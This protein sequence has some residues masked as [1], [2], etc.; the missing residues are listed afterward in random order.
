MAPMQGNS[1]E[2]ERETAH[3]L[4]QL[5]KGTSKDAATSRPREDLHITSARK[6]RRK[7]NTKKEHKRKQAQDDLGYR[8]YESPN[9]T[10]QAPSPFSLN[11]AEAEI[12]PTKPGV[13]ITESQMTLDDIPSD[14]EGIAALYREFEEEKPQES[15]DSQIQGADT[16][17][18]SPFESPLHRGD[19]K[20][21]QDLMHGRKEECLSRTSFK[22]SE[23]QKRL[24]EKKKKKKQRRSSAEAVTHE[25]DSDEEV[26]SRGYT[27]VVGFEAFD[28]AFGGLDFDA[29]DPFGD[30]LGEQKSKKRKRRS[31]ADADTVDEGVQEPDAG[32][33]I[34]EE[35]PELD[36]QAFDDF[37][38]DQNKEADIF[39]EHL[40]PFRFT[41]QSTH[42]EVPASFT[43]RG[44]LGAA[45]GGTLPQVNYMAM[46]QSLLDFTSPQADCLTFVP[47]NDELIDPALRTNSRTSVEQD[48]LM[49]DQVPDTQLEEAEVLRQNE[50]GSPDPG[51]AAPSSSSRKKHKKSV[52][53]RFWVDVPAYVSPYQSIEVSPD[54]GAQSLPH[55]QQSTQGADGLFSSRAPSTPQASSSHQNAFSAMRNSAETTPPESKRSERHR[56]TSNDTSLKSHMPIQSGTYTEREIMKLE[57]FRDEYLVANDMDGYAFNEL[58]HA[59]FM[60][61]PQVRELWQEIRSILP[62][63]DVKQ[64]TKFCRR[65]FHNFQARGVWTPEEDEMLNAAVE[66]H[67]RAWKAV[68]ASIDRHPED[69]R[70][71]WRNYLVN[72][73]NRNHEK[74]TDAEV[75][76][77]AMAID[78]CVYL[79]KRDR[80]MKKALKYEGREMPVSEDESDHERAAQRLVNWQ[81][82]SD[83]MGHHGGGRSRLQCSMKWAQ[84][85]RKVRKAYLKEAELARIDPSTQ[86]LDTTPKKSN[87]GW[88]LRKG[89]K[90]ANNMKAGDKQDLLL[91]LTTCPAIDEDN[92]PWRNLGPDGF[93]EKW[94]SHDKRAAWMKLRGEVPSPEHEDYHEVANRLY[95][96]ICMTEGDHLD[97]RGEPESVDENSKFQSSVVNNKKK[98]KAKAL[99]EDEKKD[100]RK[101]KERQKY[102]R[103]KERKKAE[104]KPKEKRRSTGLPH[105]NLSKEYVESSD[106]ES[107]QEVAPNGQGSNF[108]SIK[109]NK[110]ASAVARTSTN[111]EHSGSKVLLESHDSEASARAEGESGDGEEAEV[112]DNSVDGYDEEDMY[113]PDEAEKDESAD[114][115]SNNKSNGHRWGD[116]TMQNIEA[117]VTPDV[118][119]E[120]RDEDD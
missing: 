119:D 71:R 80:R 120:E 13:G 49:P 78:E 91:A 15:V 92:I 60:G 51:H 29:A 76:N 81:A 94:T 62:N 25:Q 26:N 42:A 2:D 55:Q 90:R 102:L 16:D 100:R 101:E 54:G 40:D 43:A 82:V 23:D 61:N 97:E 41:K 38:A 109:Q 88:R 12:P 83:R 11:D 27:P 31:G 72:A 20:Y 28:Q 67:G 108:Q 22:R 7:S 50:E 56:A 95:T 18:T 30:I 74:W 3:A 10:Q 73:E 34:F 98:G 36:L 17:I 52:A 63:R 4:L 53:R 64:L 48:A 96:K 37:F 113:D 66:E 103:R 14:E 89:A 93:K 114:Q 99:T 44:E 46:D 115:R 87:A 35:T 104:S 117:S 6:R 75:R 9:I 85:K 47:D 111:G 1:D 32:G 57:D 70:D 118:S 107:D 45:E 116:L 59:P 65:R 68:G 69:C 105:G 112:Q 106:E 39:G 24:R 110:K 77:L 58:I 84:L 33:F 86:Q 8:D 19:L 5:G 79:M 21:N